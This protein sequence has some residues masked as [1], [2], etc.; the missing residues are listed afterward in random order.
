M[1]GGDVTKIRMGNEEI[2]INQLTNWKI[3]PVHPLAFLPF[4]SR[5]VSRG[6]NRFELQALAMLKNLGVRQQS[7]IFQGSAG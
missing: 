7:R 3:H 5:L 4:G 2:Q 1:A 6:T